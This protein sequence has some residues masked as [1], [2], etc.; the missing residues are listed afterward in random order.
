MTSPSQPGARLADLQAAIGRHGYLLAL[1]AAVVA[2]TATQAAMAQ[3]NSNALTQQELN[4]INNQPIAP[5]AKSQLNQPREPSFQLRERD[6]TQVTEYRDKGRST[7]IQ[8]QSGFGT[9]YE[10][11]KPED[12]SPRIRDH[13]V[14][15]VPSVNLKF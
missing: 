1:A 11:S 2:L 6:G 4:K 5:A 7:E 9:K 8:V 3:E 15:R 10:M 12:S 14:N 13:D